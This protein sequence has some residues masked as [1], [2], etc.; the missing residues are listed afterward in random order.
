M[1]ALRALRAPLRRALSSFTPPSSS[2]PWARVA[3]DVKHSEASGERPPGDAPPHRL[4]QRPEREPEYLDAMRSIADPALHVR[5]IEDELQEAVAGAL[6]RS[7]DAVG[8]GRR[9]RR[10]S[11][12]G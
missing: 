4:A 10:C 5:K 6:K 11:D 1:A 2:T 3:V 9:A 7:S 8:A 12:W